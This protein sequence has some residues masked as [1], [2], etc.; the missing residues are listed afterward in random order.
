MFKIIEESTDQFFDQFPDQKKWLFE[1][2]LKGFLYEV[3]SGNLEYVW[4]VLSFN[5][6]FVTE[7]TLVNQMW[8]EFVSNL[9]FEIRTIA[10]CCLAKL[11]ISYCHKFS[12][13]LLLYS[14]LHSKDQLYYL[15][16]VK[17]LYQTLDLNEK[18][19]DYYSLK[20][21]KLYNDTIMFLKMLKRN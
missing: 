10:I 7:K 6:R 5:R 21:M 4:S 11:K 3:F 17:K 14:L 13:I 2:I 12:G 16:S 9:S 1:N 19:I 20:V 18:D 15:N 8:S